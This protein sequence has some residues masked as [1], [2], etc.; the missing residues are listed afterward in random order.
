MTV[1]SVCPEFHDEWQELQVVLADVFSRSSNIEKMLR[2]VCE[3]YFEGQS[4]EIK[5]Y[6]IAVDAFGRSHDFDPTKDSIVRVEA[7]RLRIKL[8]RYYQRE[9][10][11]HLIQIVLPSGGY[12]PRFIRVASGRVSALDDPRTA[13]DS[14]PDTAL[15]IA[16]VHSSILAPEAPFGE[17]AV[18][19]RWLWARPWTARTAL[20]VIGI[21]T[22]LTIWHFAYRTR[23]SLEPQG[24]VLIRHAPESLSLQS[25]PSVVSP[26]IRIMAG[27]DAPALT[28]EH[29]DL[30]L[31]DRYFQ[32]GDAESIPP[33]T[34]SFATNPSIYLRR[35]RGTFSYAIPL[36]KGV[37][38]LRLHFADSFFGQDAPQGGGESS[39]LFDVKA[40]GKTLLDD[41]DVIADAGGSNTA[42][43]KIFSN[44][45]PASDGLLH[46]DFIPYRNVAFVNAIEIFP[47][48]SRK[49]HALR[50][51]TGIKSYKD[52]AGIVWDSDRYYRGGVQVHHDEN[53]STDSKLCEFQDERFGNF[54]YAI[55]VVQEGVYTVKL[56][57][58]S[59]NVS[60]VQP[61]GQ[62][63]NVFNVYLNGKILLEDLSIPTGEPQP[64]NIVKQFAGIKPNAQGKLIFSFVPVRGYA[65]L[66]GIEIDQE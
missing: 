11:Q 46:L 21:L 57:F 64:K 53:K 42:D 38:E 18:S 30:W 7:H 36:P 56:W 22:A 17:R 25:S 63:D 54:M 13:Q 24:D 43:V 9:G 65:S 15:F 1:D 49:M 35:R 5:E 44:I 4:I 16:P 45:E 66:N 10:S 20:I 27:T 41:F 47:S 19:T 26:P 8:A 52:S 33:K 48:P 2:Y 3:K 14:Q 37:Y 23:S 51:Y 55:P 40:N 29:G 61:S 59:G 39:R 6:S 12:V 58:C 32:N 50:V 34:I 60:N 62:R 28:D 31:G